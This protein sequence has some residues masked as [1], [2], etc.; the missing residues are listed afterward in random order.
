MRIAQ[1]VG[2]YGLVLERIFR[3][4]ARQFKPVVIIR[5]GADPHYLD[6]LAEL[7]LTSRG[8]WSLGRSASEVADE[9]GCGLVDLLCGGN[10]TGH[11]EWGLYALLLGELNQEL[12]YH[13]M[14]HLARTLQRYLFKKIPYRPVL[15]VST[16]TT[17][18]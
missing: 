10:N 6:E 2:G 18:P 15:D 9:L 12:N 4:I 7:G 1:G 16:A 3:P 5:M 14:T 13:H 17:R 8:L 11:D